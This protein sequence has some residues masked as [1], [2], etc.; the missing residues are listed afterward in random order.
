M[1]F[2]RETKIFKLAELL[3][4]AFGNYKSGVVT[5]TILNFFGGLLDGIGITAVIPLL[6]IATKN[7]AGS[8]N[9]ITI[10]IKSLFDFLHISF[11]PKYLLIFICLLF[12]VRGLIALWANYI[13]L[14]ITFEYEEKKRIELFSLFMSARWP[15]LLK[16]KLGHLE[17]VLMT[18]VRFG[19]LLLGSLSSVL[20]LVVSLAVYILVSLNLSLFITLA[21]L[22]LGAF[23]FYFFKP[24]FSNTKIIAHDI[25]DI[26]KKI[27]HF[28]NE[29]TMGMKT[30]KIMDA[31]NSVLAKGKKYFQELKNLGIR[32][33]LVKSVGGVLL[34]PLSVIFV[35]S[36]FAFLY[37][38]SSNFSIGV[39]TAIV[40]LTQR[41]FTYFQQLQTNLHV[42][43]EGAPYLEALML[44]ENEAKQ[45]AEL[46]RGR[47]NFVF[48]SSIEFKDVYFSYNQEKT[49]E[50]LSGVNFSINKGE[51]IGLIGSSG[52]GK[53]TIVDLILR[54]FKPNAG[55]ILLDGKSVENVNL[56]DWRK[57]CGYVSQDIFLINDTL[58]NNIRFYDNGITD[59][60]IK[61]AAKLANIYDFIESCPNKFETIIGE[62]GIMLSVGQRQRVVIARILARKTKFLIFDE[63][64]SALD[65]ESESQ[66]QEVIRR[67]KGKMTI[68]IIAHRLSTVID[69]DKLVVLSDGKI[70]E[71]GTPPEL[72]KDK[73]SYFYKAYYFK[74]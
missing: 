40:Y 62:R 17:T 3:Y 6:A 39:M 54:L 32:I 53:T 22:I 4:Q 58:A 55:A 48:D 69:C 72:L 28:V 64:T 59:K 61:E 16:Q 51:T 47:E 37:K 65:N 7:P 2:F 38:T 50:V 24:L 41:I 20:T 5:L 10:W 70:T 60:E 23:I 35:S 68:F 44:L 12:V 34:Q 66:I 71:Q 27:A 49:K 8:D 67:L 74:K 14:K 13:G 1:S 21:T 56:A 26:N 45:N 29:N 25:E 63:A 33:N 30:V 43:S 31:E 42:L 11:F 52:S 19:S 9:L 73:D 15:F 46:E 18:N 36:I 57:N